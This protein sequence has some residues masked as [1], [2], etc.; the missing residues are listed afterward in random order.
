MKVHGACHCGAIE[1]EADVDPASTMICHCSDCQ[2]L[3]GAPFRASVVAPAEHFVLK[4]G[5]PNIYVKTAESGN[6]RAQGFC[7]TCGT[8]IYSAMVENTPAYFL[9]V[10]PLRERAQLPPQKQIWCQSAQGWTMNLAG[11]EKREKQQ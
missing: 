10:G 3:S 4:R 11:V 6:K 1:Y 5:T 7:G 8:A 9:R 2:T